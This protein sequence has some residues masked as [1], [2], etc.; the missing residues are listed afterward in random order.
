MA[1]LGI[2]LIVVGILGVI[3]NYKT[4]KNKWW[5]AW[6][7]FFNFCLFCWYLDWNVEKWNH[8]EIAIMWVFMVLNAV[9]AVFLW[10]FVNKGI[11]EE[12]PKSS[13][14]VEM[15]NYRKL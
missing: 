2:A 10:I 8:P 11:D 14:D 6:Y 3:G 15:G 4:L 9:A 13:K 7:F 1:D 12:K 5:M